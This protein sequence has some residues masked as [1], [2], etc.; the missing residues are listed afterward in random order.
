MIGY[1]DSHN[2]DAKD[3][4]FILLNLK[5]KLLGMAI[6]VQVARLPPPPHS[7]SYLLTREYVIP[8]SG[9]H[10]HACSCVLP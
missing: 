4:V 6:I 9:W 10:G 2:E 7:M 5:G 8:Q 3:T 1:A